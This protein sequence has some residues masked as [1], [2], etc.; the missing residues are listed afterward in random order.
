MALQTVTVARQLL[1]S[2]HLDI[3]TDGNTTEDGVLYVVRADM[4]YVIQ[5]SQWS[6][7]REEAGSNTSIVAL[8]VV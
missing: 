5:V 6:E 4:L 8:R 7:S 1:I 2:D 3:P